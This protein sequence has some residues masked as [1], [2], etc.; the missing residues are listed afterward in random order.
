MLKCNKC[1]VQVDMD[2]PSCPLCGAALTIVDDKPLQL[3][4]PEVEPIQSHKIGIK[5]FLFL[6]VAACVICLTVNLLLW[7]GLLWS[8]IPIGAICYMWVTL[9]LVI[10]CWTNIGRTL[11]FQ[12]VGLSI[13]L[14]II[15]MISGFHRWSLNYVIPFLLIGAAGI[16]TVV[17][18]CAKLKWREYMI[19]QLILV[20]LGFI[21]LLLLFMGWSTVPWTA[22]CSAVYALLTLVGTVIFADKKV[23]NEIVKRF[24]F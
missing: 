13:F 8:A 17:L 4:Y 23:K 21:P 5:I 2:L 9:W 7:H 18:M 10:K 20:I 12:V 1:G 16:V 24:H 6:S 15:D 11:I 14:L 19:Y 22:V 3:Y